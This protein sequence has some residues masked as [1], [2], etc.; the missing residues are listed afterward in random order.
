[1][2]R[3]KNRLALIVCLI[4]AVFILAGGLNTPASAKDPI[5]IGLMYDT[6]GPTQ[7]YG[8]PMSQAARDM[9]N[10]TNKKGGIDGHPIKA[11]E[12]E[13]GYKV[14]L[15]VEAYERF[16][17]A[18]AV[19]YPAWG[20]PIIYALA[21]RTTA[22][23]IPTITP[24]FG[25]AD[26]TD[27]K[28]FPYIFPMAANYW[29]QAGAGV[30]YVMDQWKA[31]GQTTP[32]K[33]AFLYWDNPAGR[34]PFPILEKLQKKL[35]YQFK[36]WGIPSPGIEQSAQILDI[37]K[38]Y[39]ADWVLLHNWS[40]SPAIS[41]K[42]FQRNG[43]PMD[44]ILGFVWAC[45]EH[46]LAGAGPGISEK[47]QCMSFAGYGH[48]YPVHKE[49]IE[50]YKAEGKAPPRE[51]LEISGPYNRGILWM[52]VPLEAIR[53]AYT[54][55]G[56]PLTGEKVK[57]GFESIRG[58]SLGG[59]IPPMDITPED[60]E[61]GGWIQIEEVKDGKFVKKVD[62]FKGFRD[63]VMEQVV[64]AGKEEAKGKK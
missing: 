54:K 26:A 7:L 31:S 44:R 46:D 22:D 19:Y 15:A 59:V 18:G 64:L 35:G 34:E 24:G 20:T 61:G 56:W 6:T 33:I 5:T 29:S 51:M 2:W 17:A 53:L 43:F 3:R 9:I 62:W 30:K 12:H 48:D 49:I 52:A 63:E 21:E 8:I 14:D 4:S 39:K 36:S 40:K 47:Y 13:M 37:T 55:F 1:M 32:P 27:G 45:S 28:R 10:L 57:N 25:R 42:E 11:I 60:H 50:M 23:K 38:R 16:K 58:F 41:I